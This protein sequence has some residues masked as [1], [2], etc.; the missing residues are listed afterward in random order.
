MHFLNGVVV[1]L[2]RFNSLWILLALYKATNFCNMDLPS[3]FATAHESL[4]L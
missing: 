1:G 3:R 2:A 4:A